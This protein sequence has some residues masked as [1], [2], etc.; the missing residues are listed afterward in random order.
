M[1]QL[2]MQSLYRSWLLRSGYESRLCG[3]QI[4]SIAPQSWLL[5]SGYESRL[6]DLAMIFNSPSWLLRS[7]YESRLMQLGGHLAINDRRGCCAAATNRD[8]Q[9]SQPYPYSPMVV[10]AA[11]RLRIE[12]LNV[13]AR[14]IRRARRGCCAA[15][16]NRD[17]DK[18]AAIQ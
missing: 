7:G 17:I 11:Q 12:T 14:G 4:A 2:L 15:A 3:L 1:L 9:S 10:A 13:G 16:T 5:R 8:E 6:L 18:T